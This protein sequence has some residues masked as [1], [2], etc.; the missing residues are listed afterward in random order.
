MDESCVNVIWPRYYDREL[1]CCGDAI[2]F[3]HGTRTWYK[4][5]YSI[6]FQAVY[7]YDDDGVRSKIVG[8]DV[9]I[10]FCDP[11]ENP[12]NYLLV[13]AWQGEVVDK[14]YTRFNTVC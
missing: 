1:V 3:N 5:V 4:T 12:D 10:R 8:H 11:E 6:E 14:V 13:C 2:Q 7:D 9:L